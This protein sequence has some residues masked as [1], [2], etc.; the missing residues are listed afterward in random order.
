MHKRH[1]KLYSCIDIGCMEKIPQ[2]IQQRII[3]LFANKNDCKIVFVTNEDIKSVKTQFFFKSKLKE[4]PK[5]DGFI[6]FTLEQF[7]YS[8]LNLSLIKSIFK[9]KYDLYFA[10]EELIFKHNDKNLK[11]I[12]QQ[13]KIFS[14]IRN[15]SK[16]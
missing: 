15:R 1:I 8:G 4:K 5:V 6:F 2:S 10:K 13:I 3:S 12:I 7:C 11:N 16:N 14:N 9:L